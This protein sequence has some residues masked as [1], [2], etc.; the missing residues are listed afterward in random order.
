MFTMPD[1]GQETL[2]SLAVIPVSVHE[3]GV[4]HRRPLNEYFV[5]QKILYLFGKFNIGSGFDVGSNGLHSLGGGVV[6]EVVVVFEDL[7]V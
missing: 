3:V 1:S 6:H 7:R 5:M 2:E 4:H